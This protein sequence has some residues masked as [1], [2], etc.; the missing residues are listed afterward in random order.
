MKNIIP[1]ALEQLISTLED[2]E[3]KYGIK[4]Y[5]VGGILVNI[6]SIFR[7]TQDIDFVVDIHSQRIDIKQYISILKGYF[8][9]PIQD[10]HQA[11][12]LAQETQ[13]IQYFDQN[14]RVKFDNYI[15]DR[16]SQSKYK[17]IGPI[18]LKRRVRDKIFN[19][20]CWVA[21]K[22]DFIISK[23]V[24]GGWQDYSD[25]LAC[26]MRF[27][28]D[29]DVKYMEEFS[30]ELGIKKELNLLKSGIEDPDE[31]FKKLNNY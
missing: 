17:R 27:S 9:I 25:A 15:L 26:W 16:V 2:I 8:F 20:D 21:S 18:A 28:S 31:Y 1:K 13:I 5:L 29:L 7:I 24:F 14:E 10:W 22:E 12:S 11:E 3:K 23:L 6:Y 30:K 4:Y 19:I